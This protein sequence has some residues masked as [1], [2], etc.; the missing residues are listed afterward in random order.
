[1][2]KKVILPALFL[3]IALT[4]TGC[5]QYYQDTPEFTT[6]EN[7]DTGFVANTFKETHDTES[8]ELNSLNDYVK[9][10]TADMKNNAEGVKQNIDSS[11]VK[12]DIAEAT[13]NA[14]EFYNDMQH[15]DALPEL[16]TPEI[17]KPEPLDLSID[18]Q[19]PMPSF[20]DL[21]ID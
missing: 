12:Q 20:D 18:T 6:E 4:A 21:K 5:N 9:Q 17:N 1:M 7:R 15:Q 8:P 11:N 14:V 3:I 19:K 13:D 2:H 10:G 16:A